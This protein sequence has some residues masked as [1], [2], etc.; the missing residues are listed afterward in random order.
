MVE[1]IPELMN[2]GIDSFK[3]EGRMKTALYVATVARTYRMAID[4]YKKDAK[5]YESRMDFFK[6]K[7]QNVRTD[8]I[9]Q[10]FSLENLMKTHR[11]TTVIH[12]LKNIHILE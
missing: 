12:I 4:D 3:I 9:R 1:H 2:S 5:L 7:L 11:Y 10:D 8:S 6:K